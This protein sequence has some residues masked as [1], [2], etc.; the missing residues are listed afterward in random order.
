MVALYLQN[1]KKI[2]II[3]IL[4]FSISSEKLLSQN[5]KINQSLLLVELYKNEVK[6][7][8]SVDVVLSFINKTNEKICLYPNCRLLLLKPKK[9]MVFDND[10]NNMCVINHLCNLHDV[11][12]LIPNDSIDILCKIAIN[13]L[14]FKKGV[15]TFYIVYAEKP[16]KKRIS[17]RVKKITSEEIS[18]FVY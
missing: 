5:G 7:N 10:I 17:Q 11:V 15:N 14:F 16:K 13:P 3:F 1:T 6:L 12:E 4:C 18:I 2:L 8:D 9:E